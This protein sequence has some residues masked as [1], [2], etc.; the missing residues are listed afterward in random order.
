M[1]LVHVILQCQD[2]YRLLGLQKSD[3][4]GNDVERE[5]GRGASGDSLDMSRG[6]VLLASGSQDVRGRI[7]LPL[8]PG[9]IC[10]GKI[11]GLNRG[12]W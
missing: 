2:V 10:G 3:A 12:T 9:N 6:H 4:I 7:M 1:E 5:Q 8:E 11:R